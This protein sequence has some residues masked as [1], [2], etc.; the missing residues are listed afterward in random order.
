MIDD[1]LADAK[2]RMVKAVEALRRELATIRTGRAS[3]GLVEG[4]KADYYGTPTPLKQIAS[5]STP[6]ARLI[7]IQPWDKQSISA[8]EKAIQKSDLGLTPANDGNVIRLTIPQLTEDRRKELAKLVRRRVEEGR[9][10]V[11]NVRRDDHEELRALQ[12]DH[13]ISE[14]DLHRAEHEL[15]KLTDEFIKE[16]DKVGEEKEAELLAV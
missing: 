15:Q 13:K 3:P 1:A 7:V 12:R 11:R 5:I 9:V 4:L 16:I 14:D 10:A 8:I 6:E 2:Q